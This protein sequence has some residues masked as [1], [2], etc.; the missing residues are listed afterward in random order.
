MNVYKC[1]FILICQ[2]NFYKFLPVP[3]SLLIKE[4]AMMGIKVSLI[5]CKTY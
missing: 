5:G 3:N 4:S 1:K 2:S